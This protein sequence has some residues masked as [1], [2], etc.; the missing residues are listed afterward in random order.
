MCRSRLMTYLWL[1][2]VGLLLMPAAAVQA[3]DYAAVLD[4]SQRAVLSTPVSGVVAEV[5]VRA[6]ERV[7]TGQLLLL[8]DQRRFR[9][10]LKNREARLRKFRLQRDE[11]RRELER[12]RELYE[13]R[14]ISAHDI[15]LAEITAATA[16]ADYASAEASL[17]LARLDLEYSE[18]HA[19]FAGVVLEVPVSAGMTVINTQQAT[20]LVVLAQP[21]P[22]LARARVPLACLAGLAGTR[23]A[24]VQVGD[25]SYSAKL[26]SSDPEPDGDG[27]YG[28]ALSFDKGDTALLAGQAA[29]VRC[30]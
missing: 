10:E 16:E 29:R 17:A 22:M 4:W 3:E 25:K 18:L 12:N 11:A 8:L 7:E 13:R 20:P 30:E 21:Q 23:T 5:R 19:P 1:A 14:V 15:E 26:S 27:H 24:T 9:S 28:V 6:G 2:V